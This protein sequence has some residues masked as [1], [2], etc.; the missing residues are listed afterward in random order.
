MTKILLPFLAAVLFSSCNLGPAEDTSSPSPDQRNRDIR[1]IEDRGA[2]GGNLLNFT[3]EY[4]SSCT[5]SVDGQNLEA[6]EVEVEVTQTRDKI[7]LDLYIMGQGYGSAFDMHEF[8]IRGNNLINSFNSQVSG[9]IGSAGFKFEDS[10]LKLKMLNSGRGIVYLDMNF[11]SG[12][13]V[14]VKA[15]LK[16]TK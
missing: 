3:G 11:N 15:S 5:G 12:S 4:K 7:S 13:S 10:G 14:Q 6:C 2:Y 9:Q 16:K 8:D 1:N